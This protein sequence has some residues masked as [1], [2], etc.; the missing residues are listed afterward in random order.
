MV[1]SKIFLFRTRFSWKLGIHVA[2]GTPAHHS[3]FKWWSWSDVDLFYNKVKFGNMGFSIEKVKTVDYSETIA[4]SD[5]KVGSS[6]HIIKYMKIC[7]YWRSRS[8]DLGPRSCTY[9]NLN[10]IFSG[11]TM[12]IWTKL[13]MKA[14]KYKEIKLWWH[15]TGH[16]TKMAAMLFYGKNPSK[17]FFSGTGWQISTKLGM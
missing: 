6:R 11:T 3:L 14:F 16:I 12:S 17:I 15:D 9:K 4:A 8:F 5:L 1:L 10:W 7:E 13:C 2:L